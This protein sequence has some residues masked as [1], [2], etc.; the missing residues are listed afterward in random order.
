MLQTLKTDCNAFCLD[1]AYWIWDQTFLQHV[2]NKSP[3]E[4]IAMLRPER[5]SV[6][7]VEASRMDDSLSLTNATNAIFRLRQD[8]KLKNRS[9]EFCM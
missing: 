6:C 4:R 3:K 1:I 2:K 9:Y 7:A 5:T 8:Y